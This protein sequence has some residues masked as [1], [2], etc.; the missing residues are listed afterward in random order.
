[1]YH[2]VARSSSRSAPTRRPTKVD[3]D[4]IEELQDAWSRRYDT[5]RDAS[6]APLLNSPRSLRAC[7]SAKVSP[8]STLQ[9]LS[10]K[11][12]LFCVLGNPHALTSLPDSATAEYRV[13]MQSALRSF[14]EAA[15]GLGTSQEKL[16]AFIAF[17]KQEKLRVPQ[18]ASL[19][20]VRRRLMA[21]EALTEQESYHQ[22]LEELA[23]MQNGG[24]SVTCRDAGGQSLRHS[25]TAHATSLCPSNVEGSHLC[26]RRPSSSDQPEETITDVRS[27][28]GQPPSYGPWPP[29]FLAPVEASNEG[30]V[31]DACS[32]GPLDFEPMPSPSGKLPYTPRDV[33]VLNSSYFSN[34]SIQGNVSNPSGAPLPTSRPATPFLL[35]RG[36]TSATRSLKRAADRKQSL[37][38]V[39]SSLDTMKNLN[40][41]VSLVGEEASDAVEVRIPARQ[42]LS[43]LSINSSE[44]EQLWNAGELAA[45]S[46]LPPAAQRSAL[47]GPTPLR[48]RVQNGPRSKHPVRLLHEPDGE[49]SRRPAADKAIGVTS[50]TST[51][52][53]TSV[54]QAV[55]GYTKHSNFASQLVPNLLTRPAS[56]QAETKSVAT[57]SCAHVS[58]TPISARGTG[59]TRKQDEAAAPAEALQK[60]YT[61]SAESANAFRRYWLPSPPLITQAEEADGFLYYCANPSHGVTSFYAGRCELRAAAFNL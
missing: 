58:E 59:V 9:K 60:G 46:R 33:S 37:L 22:Q 49:P 7:A 55:R 61:A 43:I 36:T 1:M 17:K 47:A 35:E 41:E 40:G 6:P 21:A 39:D 4:T 52:E 20:E 31:D 27:A 12:H 57:S 8:Y 18:L 14:R 28:H 45:S 42:D 30:G 16:A 38:S 53:W 5:L 48:E 23:S 34:R 19:R 11:Q 29:A 3:L 32:A 15:V 54:P 50:T 26:R 56:P 25:S 10:L 13:L 51:T 24:A 2:N 44:L